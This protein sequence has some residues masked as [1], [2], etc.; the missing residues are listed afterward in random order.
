MWLELSEA[1]AEFVFFAPLECRGLFHC[2]QHVE[3]ERDSTL[4]A[5]KSVPSTGRGR[6]RNV[7]FVLKMC[8][9][10]SRFPPVNFGKVAEVI[11]EK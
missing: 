2:E 4:L 11:S 6:A 1:E 3:K 8:L 9:E 5:G 10:T 7:E